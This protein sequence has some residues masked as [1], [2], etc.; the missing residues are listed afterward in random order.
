M[1]LSKKLLSTFMIVFAIFAGFA[2]LPVSDV[3]ANTAAECAARGGTYDVGK[4]ACVEP[5]QTLVGEGVAITKEQ[6]HL[7]T[8][9]ASA[10]T[11]VGTMYKFAKVISSLIF[12]V[13]VIMIGWAGFKYATS[14]GDTKVTEQAKMQI[15]TAGI[16]IGVALF[17][18]IIVKL[19]A[20]VY[21]V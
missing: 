13:A 15:I 4:K 1:I 7:E 19:F 20:S 8:G 18:I 9:N 21:S 2:V 5:E 11:I 3:F 6:A 12:G 14:Q 10:N 16:G 17:A